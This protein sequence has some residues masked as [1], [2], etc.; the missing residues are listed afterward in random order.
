MTGSVT[1]TDESRERSVRRKAEYDDSHPHD[2]VLTINKR[3]GGQITIPLLKN[4]R[5]NIEREDHQENTLL[6][7]KPLA[8]IESALPV[9]TGYGAP[10][11]QAKAVALLRPGYLYVFRRGRLWRELEIGPDSK[12][13]DVD[14]TAA[15]NEIDNP[16][17]KLRIERPAEGEWFDDV[18]VPVF[19]QGQAVM[20]DF[21]MAYSEIQWDWSYIQKLE[22][23]DNARNARTTGIGHAWAVTTAAG[24]SFKTGFPASR[25]EDLPEL[26]ERDL[27]IELMLENPRDFTPAF[28]T[29]SGSELC[30]KLATRLREAQEEGEQPVELDI[31][32]DSDK[33]RLAHLRGQKGLACIALPDPLFKLRHSLAQ[34]HL[35]LH[36]L[37][38]IDVS[39]QKKPMVH[40]A[41]L[42]RQAVFDPQA[43]GKKP[44]LAKYAEAI[45]RE[46]LDEVLHTS[47]KNHAIRVIEE[48]AE[49]LIVM[50]KS[51]GLDPVFEDYRTC[52]DYAICE[53]YLLVADSLNLLQQIPGV[54]QA[55]GVSGG[56]R[57]LPELRRW[58]V[59]SSFLSNWAPEMAEGGAEPFLKSLEKLA[60]DNTEIDDALLKRLSVQSLIY[61]EKQLSEQNDGAASGIKGVANAGKVSGMIISSLNEWSSAILAVGKRLVEEDLIL[62]AELPRIMQAA[63]SNFALADPELRRIDIMNR[64]GARASGSIVG[65]YGNGIER[66]LTDF[67]RTKGVLSRAK[68]YLYADLLDDSNRV[69]ASTSPARMS[70]AVEGA[71]QKAAGTTMVFVAPD[72]HPEVRKL[73][74]IRVDLAKRVGKVVDGPVISRGLVALAAF[75]VFLELNNLMRASRQEEDTPLLARSKLAGAT[76]DLVAAS[77]KLSEVLGQPAFARNAANGRLHQLATRPLFDMKNWLLIGN[78]LKAVRAATV[79]KVAGLATFIAGAAGV[80]LSFWEMRISLS[81]KDFD[82][83][84]GHGIAMTGSLVVLAS[85][86]MHTLLM[87]PGWGWAIF[88]LSM[89]VGG[90]LY[91]G[92]ATDDTFEQL[93]KRGPWGTHPDDSLP[94]GDDKAYYSQLLALLSPI[95]VTAQRYAD[96]EPDPELNH[97]DYRPK[98]D[99]YVITLQLPL[100]SRI[101]LHQECVE[102]SPASPFKLVVQEVAYLSSTTSVPTKGLMESTTST[103][104]LKTTPLT[105]VTARQSMPH[106]SAVRFLVRREI[107]DSEY[108]SSY[109]QESVKTRVRVGLQVTLNTEFGPL[110]FPAPVFEDY[111]TF[112]VTRHNQPPPKER[113][114][115]NP[116]GQPDSPYWYF[117]EVS[118]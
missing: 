92:S 57:I 68:D 26:R 84:T 18:L 61:L 78:R 14:L 51:G 8:E 38:A 115:V 53:A 75:N 12:V 31:S 49:D 107:Q 45:D 98:P 54:L 116:Y 34:L 81:N 118:V 50:I 10:I 69:I 47:E 67:D 30:V 80:G 101:N 88:G 36:Y 11:Y 56:D 16:E 13:S 21:R 109:Y 48:H 59:D 97:P 60:Q 89:A 90:G 73:S 99:D 71:I 106:Q 5:S 82:A 85:P 3:E 22:A 94:G 58:I 63:L 112:D 91:A 102:G 27:G 74:L 117:T 70:D 6:R 25:I 17:S 105:K 76:A 9:S 64:A 111:E 20:H 28:E 100:V 1:F 24:I 65:V 87:I 19:L 33:D 108:Q 93:L 37:D 104:M 77:L 95:Q 113:L 72:S 29:P 96:V 23:D 43:G 55:Q 44:S 62:Q 103:R 40:S 66:G 114:L 7:I 4:A 86:L 32:C 83:A 41:M 39:I 79:V 110:V 42:I 46:K 35:A 15:R 52:S 2:L